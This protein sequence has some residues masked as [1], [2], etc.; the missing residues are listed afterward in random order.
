MKFLSDLPTERAM[1]DISKGRLTDAV[2]KVV[3]GLALNKQ[4]M[5]KALR[6]I[7][8]RERLHDKKIS[9]IITADKAILDF[10]TENPDYDVDLYRKSERND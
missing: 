3:E 5:V 7:R 8:F 2:K 9:A 1:K 6:M 4:D 10:I